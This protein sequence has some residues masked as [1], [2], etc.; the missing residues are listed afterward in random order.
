[1]LVPGVRVAEYQARRRTVLRSLKGSAAVIF[2]GDGAPP[3]SGQW[4]PDWNF[5]YLTGIVDEPGAAVV[6]NPKAED[7]RRRIVLLLKPLNPEMESWDGIRET[8]SQS[9][10]DQ[11]GFESVMRIGAM[12]RLMNHAVSRCGSLACLHP[13]ANYTAPVSSDLALYRKITERMVGVSITNQTSLL[14]SMRGRKS[15]AELRLMKKAIAA[16]HAGHVAAM[17]AMAPGVSEHQV[18]RVMENGFL[19]NGA[20]GPAYNSIVGS[21]KNGAVL[22]YSVNNCTCED[23]DLLVIDAGASVNHYAA[24]I[25]RTYPVNGRFSKQQKHHYT[26][27]LDALKAAI[28]VVKPGN[29]LSDADQ[30][31]RAIIDKAGYGDSFIHGIGHHLGIEVHDVEPDGPL[32]PGMV[33]TIEPGIYYQDQNFGIR[34][35]DNILVTERGRTNLSTAIPREIDDIQQT[36]AQARRR[37]KRG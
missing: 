17:G 26:V 25:T 5:F 31:A 7:A 34:I 30:A 15:P 3:L 23:G 14:S 35:E 16:T 37:T 29:R 20:L 13:F 4:L 10:R 19:K 6:F 11:T 24:D 12:P 27:V 32:K 33:V 18:Q 36:M 1:M 9:L 21:G 2:A 8:I 22:H 28:R